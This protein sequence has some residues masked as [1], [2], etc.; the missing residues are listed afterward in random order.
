MV[1]LLLRGMSFDCTEEGCFQLL[2]DRVPCPILCR[3]GLCFVGMTENPL[4]RLLVYL[5]VA[6][7]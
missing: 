6:A 2:L 4:D 5:Y 3:L 7:A 1:M